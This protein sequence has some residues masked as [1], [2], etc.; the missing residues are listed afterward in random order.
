MVNCHDLSKQEKY[1]TLSLVEYLEFI[2][3]IA[4]KHFDEGEH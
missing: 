1:E 4:L 3:R 2:S